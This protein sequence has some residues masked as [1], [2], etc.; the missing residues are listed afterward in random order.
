MPGRLFNAI[1]DVYATFLNI[2]FVI[3]TSYVFIIFV[4]LT[5]YVL[6]S[7]CVDGNASPKRI[8][9]ISV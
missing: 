3:L 2:I 7:F 8:Y 9:S 5:S 4:I 1:M 6:S